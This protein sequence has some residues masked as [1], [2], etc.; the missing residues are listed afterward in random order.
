MLCWS[1]FIDELS[2]DTKFLL[3]IPWFAALSSLLTVQVA[4]FWT[5]R[6]AARN[7]VCYTK[8]LKKKKNPHC[9]QFSSWVKSDA[10]PPPLRNNKNE[11]WQ[12]SLL[13]AAIVHDQECKKE[14]RV[15]LRGLLT[16]IKLQ[17]QG[18][19]SQDRP[20]VQTLSGLGYVAAFTAC[21]S[22]DV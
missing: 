12:N 13:A 8:H 11:Y 15:R 1:F 22:L 6:W 10:V 5:K 9:H 3:S 7:Q 16:N 19:R 21:F 4:T 20:R 14:L 2:P 17:S 18:Q